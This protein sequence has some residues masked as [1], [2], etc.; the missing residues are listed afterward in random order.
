MGELA[1]FITKGIGKWVRREGA[2]RGMA[3]REGDTQGAQKGRG[4][5]EKKGVGRCLTTRV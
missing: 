5:E 4:K 1:K 2:G 3:G